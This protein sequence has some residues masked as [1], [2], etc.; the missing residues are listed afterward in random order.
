MKAINKPD[1]IG[2][3]IVMAFCALAFFLGRGLP[4]EARAFPLF[5]LGCLAVLGACLAFNGWRGKRVVEKSV[6]EIEL[7]MEDKVKSQAEAGQPA[8]PA[9]VAEPKPESENIFLIF[10]TVLLA[11]AYVAALPTLGFTLSTPIFIF[12][13]LRLLGMRRYLTLVLI[14]VLTT[15]TVF[16]VFKTVMYVSIPGGIFDPTELMYRY[17]IP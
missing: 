14:S 11:V 3:F 17:L 12:V 13:T 7:E 9:S 1:L 16:V 5:L 6:F 10:L 2:G 4:E 8:E 15:V